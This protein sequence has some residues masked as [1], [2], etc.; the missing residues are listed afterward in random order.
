MKAAVISCTIWQGNMEN[1][2][3]Y[4]FRSRFLFSGIIGV[5]L[6]VATSRYAYPQSGRDSLLNRLNSTKSDTEKVNRLND[7]AWYYVFTQIDSSVYYGKA[8]LNLSKQ[9]GYSQGI[10]I[11]ANT[12]L[13]GLSQSSNYSEAAE[14]GFSAIDEMKRVKDTANLAWLY[15]DMLVC[16]RDMADYPTALEYGYKTLELGKTFQLDSLRRSLCMGLMGSVYERENKLDSAYMFSQAALDI[17]VNWSGVMLTIG[18]VHQK[19]NNPDSALFYFHSGLPIAKENRVSIDIVDINANI[20]GIFEARN[21]LDSALWYLHN[22][23]AQEGF[24]KYPEGVM[25][26]TTRL[27]TIYGKKGMKDSVLKYQG[28]AMQAKDQ[29]FNV[30]KR[31]DAQKLLFNERFREQQLVTQEREARSRMKIYAL[32]GGLLAFL[33]ILGLLWRNNRQKQKSQ[34]ELRQKNRE[35]EIEA[36]LEKVRSRSLAMHS[37]E[38]LGEV[39]FVVQEKLKE[40]GIV[41]G[42]QSAVIIVF[43]QGYRVFTQ[44][45][46]S[47]WMPRA[48]GFKTPFIDNQILADFWESREK[49]IEY[50][51]KQYS[52][53]TK[54]ALFQ[55]FFKLLNVPHR[56][57][58][59]KII[60]ESNQYSFCAAI[61]KNSS[62]S[63]ASFAGRQLSPEEGE[64]L[65]RFARVFEQCYIRFLDLQK[66]EAQA[67]EAN[68]E[69]SLERVR[70]RALAMQS[71]SELGNIIETLYAEFR[72]LDIALDR[73]FIMIFDEKA[74]G[75]TWW[76]GSPEEG[77]MT[78]GYFVPFNNVDPDA[79]RWQAW[80][81]KK[82]KWLFELKGETKRKWDKYIFYHTELVE[83][84]L[85][86]KQYMES[87]DQ[88]YWW[89]SF[90]NFGSM[91]IATL[92]P[93]E[94]RQFD[95]LV[96]FAKVFDLAYTRFNDLRDAEKRAREARIELALERVRARTMAMQK[97]GELT[98]VAE[99]LF[100]QVRDLGIKA[101]TTGFNIWSED[102]NS[103]VDY[104]TD[105]NGGFMEPYTVH[106]EKAEAFMEMRD[107]RK[108]G[109]EF[110]VQHL[111]GERL[112]KAYAAL[113]KLGDKHQFD[114]LLES[115]FQFPTNQ[116][117]HVV[118]GSRV[119]LLFITYEPVPEAHDIFIRF[120][121]VFEQTYTRFVDLQK[122]EEQA[123]EAKIEVSLERVRARAM[124]MQNSEELNAL[125]A[126]VFDELTKLELV[127]T[128]CVI[129]IFDPISNDAKWWMA[130]NEA[131]DRPMSFAVPYHDSPPV[132]AY[133]SAW[134]QKLLKWTY[135]LEGQVKKDWDVILFSKTELKN[136]PDFVIAGMKAPD[137]VYLNAS[138]NNFGCLT[139]ASLESLSD[140]HFDILLRFAKVF[141]LTY[142][143]FN[144][145]KQAE[146]QAREARI[147]AALER[148]RARAM[149]MHSSQDLASTASLVFT[150]LRKLGINPIRCGV[151][152]LTKDSRKAQLYSAT[153]KADGDHLS[154]IGWVELSGH[155]VLTNIYDYWANS[156]E[157]FPELSGL[158]LKAYYEQLMSGL[159]VPAIPDWE[160]GQIQFGHF[161]RIS[162]GCLYAWSDERYSENDV[163]ILK[164]FAGIIDLTF[165]RYFELQKSEANAKE[166]NRRASLD[167]VRAEI[168]SMR[169]TGDLDRI[170]PLIWS[171]LT[172]LNV[173]FVRCGVFIMDDVKKQSHTFLSTPDGKA[174][175]AFNL[176]YDIGN[177]P[178]VVKHWHEKKIFVDHW[179]DQEFSVLADSLLEQ[180]TFSSKDDY[181]NTLPRE[182]IFLHFLPFLQGMLYVGNTEALNETDI[183]LVQSVADAF[184]TA[185]S[186]YEDFN[187]LESAKEQVEKT[188]DELKQAQQQLIQSEKMASLGQLTA[189]IAH[190]IQNPLNF[191]NNFSDVSAELLGEMS[192]ELRKGHNA[193][194]MAIAEDVMENLGK[195]LHHG[196]RADEIVKGM[197]QHSRT[198]SGQKE[199]TD[200]NTLADEYLR[201]A[202][203]GLRAKDKSF[204]ASFKTEFDESVGMVNVMPQEIGRVLVNLI[205]N[206]FFAVN[207]RRKSDTNGYEPAVTISTRKI[208]DM[209]ELAVKDNGIGIPQR[210]QDKIFQPFFTTKPTGQGTGLGLSL[211]Y[212]IV[213]AHGGEL[214]VESKE[215]EGSSFII[216]LPVENK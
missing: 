80:R 77:V 30:Q 23:L 121:R 133:L 114:K 213:K 151:G 127:L 37:S 75:T 31:R 200:L 55:Y 57:E 70:S 63:I 164:R 19:R 204:N 29:L 95:I 58:T 171:E 211:S 167:R 187:N 74:N 42:F 2:S 102:N 115:G 73:V 111:D 184:S 208:N 158:E 15:I 99:L 35:L 112:E 85:P 90:A 16:Y 98:E 12:L 109:E 94:E 54:N 122:A 180:G 1:D 60:F 177:M 147:E 190:E 131:P 33:V 132:L 160:S 105:A 159:S 141:D 50:Y 66:A 195:I 140:E 188:L 82:E 143:R 38:E 119:S 174:I 52:P 194:A 199:P 181:M 137:R 96:R 196:K 123:R 203:H 136:L 161:I 56:G 156:E 65:K 3:R 17:N 149:A 130:N 178:T 175:G 169:K 170:T 62:I 166:A 72:K 28:L 155:P 84:P 120:G 128:R 116:Y 108:S 154:L 93:P 146:S 4:S 39:I 124:A 78:R 49:G 139:L 6:L 215:G 168:A 192:A 83:L 13:I 45:V 134:K 97:S 189:G 64:I 145:L 44:W 107:A 10:G 176:S 207:E 20:S 5:L 67:R 157:Y 71:S 185:Y 214:S 26:T 186:R 135:N 79:E 129:M 210:V 25:T 125:I 92:Q 46:V 69:A 104:V 101:W 202:Y 113:R 89:A 27:A 47:D 165:R 205:N 21:N 182:G 193:E 51:E 163:K 68:I 8:S 86:V 11:S 40:L 91:D 18:I 106:T 212:D 179:G 172:A 150:E 32:L 100:R 87:V 152:L 216:S 209:V 81:D 142:T 22:S 201:L 53:E 206:A 59:E 197:L 162:I 153:S 14:I 191:V 148:V 43:E 48:V 34:N 88:V 24:D 183:Q 36:V 110:Y 126:T 117:D 144:D 9:I 138:F 7:L 103:Y 198:S 118:F 76:I 61:E 41:T 173:P